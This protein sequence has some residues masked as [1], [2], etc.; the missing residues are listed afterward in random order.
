MV[1][2]DAVRAT[3]FFV[4]LLAAASVVALFTRRMPA[5]PY[6]VG[7]VVL[8]L[9]VSTAN[10]G[11]VVQIDPG[12]LLAVLL[13]GL[14]FDAAYRT[15]LRILWTTLPAVTFLAVPGVLITAA[16][17]AAA[18]SLVLGLDPGLSF[19]VG[20]MLAATDPAAVITVMRHVRAPRQLATL[21]EA[22]SLFNDGTGIV[23][24][25]IALEAIRIGIAPG[26][27]V[28]SL[29]ST[30]F[31]STL[32]GALIGFVATR[33]VVLVEDRLVELSVSVVAAYGSYLLADQL[34]MSGL[35]ATVVCGLVFGSYGRSAMTRESEQAID[36]VWEFAGFLMTSLV[37]GLIGLVIALPQLAAAAAPALVAAITLLITRAVTVYLGLG[38]ASRLAQRVGWGR[39]LPVA[40]LHLI[41][42]SGLRG[43]VSVALALSLPADLPQRDLLQGT[44]FGCVLLT[45][46]VQGTT[47]Q[48]L[49]RALGLV[50]R[51]PA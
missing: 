44:V 37:F 41:G 48:P 23:I 43:A 5:M 36:T 7:L 39:Q 4:V 27:L 14:V 3:E 29:L 17:V 21:I 34:G 22:E 32:L 19:L 47:A 40:W 10:P 9:A 6:S 8:G 33:A 38:S 50:A 45:L 18:L 35:I 20:T 2:S 15:D 1:D 13:P 49:V 25:A 26:A 16:A 12:L 51:E 42:W 24:F 30:V 46:L 11:V 31:V 28:G